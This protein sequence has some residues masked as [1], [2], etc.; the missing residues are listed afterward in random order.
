H[1][2]QSMD[3]IQRDTDRDFF[4]TAEQAK[5]YRIVD[6]VISSKPT[7]RPVPEVVVTTK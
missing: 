5:D 6:E 7:T 1:T 3:K 4:M 2:G